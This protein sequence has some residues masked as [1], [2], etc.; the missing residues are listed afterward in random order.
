L[1]ESFNSSNEVAI[2]KLTPPAIQAVQ[3]VME[4]K[5]RLFGSAGKA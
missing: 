3:D 5:I 2:Y 1:Q 4:R